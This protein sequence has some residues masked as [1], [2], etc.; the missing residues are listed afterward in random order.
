MI[1]DSRPPVKIDLVKKRGKIKPM[2]YRDL[3]IGAL[4]GQALSYRQLAEKFRLDEKNKQGRFELM[5]ILGEL[6]DLKGPLSVAIDRK[7]PSQI[8][9]HPVGPDTFRYFIKTEGPLLEKAGILSRER[10]VQV[11]RNFLDP[12]RGEDYRFFRGGLIRRA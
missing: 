3:V 11:G 4:R 7:S 6:A 10:E 5:N 2:L 12:A 8:E 1:S 9:G